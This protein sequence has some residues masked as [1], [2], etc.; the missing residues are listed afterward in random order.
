MSVKQVDGEGGDAQS[1]GPILTVDPAA[2]GRDLLVSNSVWLSAG[3][4]IRDASSNLF[5]V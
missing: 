5:I 3:G 4:T 1:W 2:M